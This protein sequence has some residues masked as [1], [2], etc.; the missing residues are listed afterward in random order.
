VRYIVEGSHKQMFLD[1]I[2]VMKAPPIAFIKSGCESALGCLL[3][4]NPRETHNHLRTVSEHGH[5][6]QPNR[7]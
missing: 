5:Q 4:A 7:L 6:Q 3:S 2:G 1:R